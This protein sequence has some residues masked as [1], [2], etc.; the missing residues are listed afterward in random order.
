MKADNN[1]DKSTNEFRKKDFNE[2]LNNR[3]QHCRFTYC[4]PKISS[5]KISEWQFGIQGKSMSLVVK[6]FVQYYPFVYVNI[7]APLA[8]MIL[9]VKTMF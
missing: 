7:T 5:I 6:F 8:E 9:M 3:E 2:I 4:V 1:C